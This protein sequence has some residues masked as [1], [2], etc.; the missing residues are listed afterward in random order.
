MIDRNNV[1]ESSKMQLQVTGKG[2]ARSRLERQSTLD[3]PWGKIP[4]ILRKISESLA[5]EFRATG[6]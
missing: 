1:G 4:P 5:R 2:G 6:D 3:L